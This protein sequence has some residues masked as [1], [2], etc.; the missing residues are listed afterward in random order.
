MMEKYFELAA[1][2]IQN[3]LMIWFISNFC[4]YKHERL[5]RYASLGVTCVLGTCV[6][7]VINNFVNYD[8][9][10]SII[11]VIIYI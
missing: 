2:I 4:G 7:A 1:S 11:A 3:F 8:G 9:L 10:L 6:I 5:R